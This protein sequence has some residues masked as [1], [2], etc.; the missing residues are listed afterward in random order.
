LDRVFQ[1]FQ[2]KDLVINW[3]K[4]SLD[5]PRRHCSWTFSVRKRD[6]GG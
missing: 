5:G 6:R 3:E 4:V 2:E 1:Q